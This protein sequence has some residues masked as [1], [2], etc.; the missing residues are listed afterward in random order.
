MRTGE[1]Q[2]LSEVPNLDPHYFPISNSY[3]G[4]NVLNFLVSYNLLLFC[5]EQLTLMETVGHNGL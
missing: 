3:N 2:Q 1:P 5:F 4:K